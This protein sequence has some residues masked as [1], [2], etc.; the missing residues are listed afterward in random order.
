MLIETVVKQKKVTE[1]EVRVCMYDFS[2]LKYAPD[3]S[4]GAGR[5][6]AKD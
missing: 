5:R 4:R 6:N 3:R 2:V 1:A